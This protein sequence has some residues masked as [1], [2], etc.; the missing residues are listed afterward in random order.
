M[1]QNNN[2]TGA[3]NY[4]DYN[5]PAL[6]PKKTYSRKEKLL[7]IPAII[8]GIM[9]VNLSIEW[10]TDVE[11]MYAEHFNIMGFSILWLCYLFAFYA[12]TWD[13]SKRSIEGWALAFAAITLCVW[14]FIYTHDALMTSTFLAIP[15]LLILHA[16]VCTLNVDEGQKPNYFAAFFEG[17]FG[18]MF[19]G[20]GDAGR[21]AKSLFIRTNNS[22]VKKALIGVI[23]ALPVLIVVSLL[24]LSADAVFSHIITRYIGTIELRPAFWRVAGSLIFAFLIYS[25]FY[26]AISGQK[27]LSYT[28]RQPYWEPVTIAVIIAL[29]LVVYSVFTYVQFAYLFG[30]NGLPYGLNYS[31]YAVS[32]FRQLIAVSAINLTLFFLA[33]RFTIKNRVI[34]AL[35]LLLLVSNCVMIASSFVRINMYIAA[36]GLT[37]LRFSAFAFNIL[38][39]ALTLLCGIHLFMPKLPVIKLAFMAFVVWYLVL[40]F[41]N[42]NAIITRHNLA[43]EKKDAAITTMHTDSV[44]LLTKYYA[45]NPNAPESAK[46][47][48]YLS[49]KLSRL[50]NMPVMTLNEYRAYSI[51]KHELKLPPVN[52]HYDYEIDAP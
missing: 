1:N 39:S 31:S 51:I 6:R 26:N 29:P 37:W 12:F 16:R 25:F 40:S 45:D 36:Y 13:K 44:P 47:E 35:L 4:P 49:E 17:I 27:T 15:C 2:N 32:G 23:I 28:P 8:L 33:H 22:A 18:W 3:Q 14:T 7:L 34:K 46:I 43:L 11:W 30:S 5:N 21:A 10:M 42:S 20:I 48:K 52:P 24:L 50:Q 9:A 38:I 19:S 41:C